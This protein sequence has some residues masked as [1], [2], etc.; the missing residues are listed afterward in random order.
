MR[1]IRLLRCPIRRKRDDFHAAT[2]RANEL[3][4]WRELACLHRWRGNR[5]AQTQHKRKRHRLNQSVGLAS[6]LEEMDEA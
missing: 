1:R 5:Y 4:V 6:V 2:A 3:L